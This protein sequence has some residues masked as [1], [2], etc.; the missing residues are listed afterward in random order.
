MS[1]PPAKWSAGLARGWLTASI[2]ACRGA[3]EPAVFFDGRSSR[4]H[5]VAL[6][7]TDRLEIADPD[8][9]DGPPLASWP[10]DAVRRVDGPDGAVRLACVA[11]PP[12]A[13]PE[14]RD[15]ATQDNIPRLCPAPARPGSA[16]PGPV[17]RI[18]A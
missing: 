3:M 9:P 4:R 14:L 5:V 1:P 18:I 11:A 15:A 8:A 17:V 7:F 6:A 10:Y 13:R 16:P 2:S 12:L